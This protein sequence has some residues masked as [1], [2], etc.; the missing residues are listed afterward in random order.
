MADFG[1]SNLINI[2]DKW[3]VC[4][5]PPGKELGKIDDSIFSKGVDLAVDE[6]MSSEYFCFF[7]KDGFHH[8]EMVPDQDGFSIVVIHYDDGE[9]RVVGWAAPVGS[10][11]AKYW[12]PTTDIGNIIVTI[13]SW[14]SKDRTN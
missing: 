11:Q 8:I 9:R 12:Q 2:A 10:E 1:A 7:K 5:F 3:R 4:Y 14:Q 13:K 6:M